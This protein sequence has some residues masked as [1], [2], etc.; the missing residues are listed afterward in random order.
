MHFGTMSPTQ[1]KETE[2]GAALGLCGAEDQAGILAIRCI[3]AARFEE[4]K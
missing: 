3:F 1:G 2:Q 4:V